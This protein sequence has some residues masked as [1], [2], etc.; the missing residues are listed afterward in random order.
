MGGRSQADRSTNDIMATTVTEGNQSEGE[1]DL[2][3]AARTKATG[4]LTRHAI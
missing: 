1:C 4:P 2:S 3:C